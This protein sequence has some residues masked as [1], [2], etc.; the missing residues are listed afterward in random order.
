VLLR[1][2]AP[3]REEVVLDAVDAPLHPLE[4]AVLRGAQGEPVAA[5]RAGGREEGRRSSLGSRDVA[6]EDR[7]QAVEPL[8]DRRR[9]RVV[10]GGA[11][12]E[13]LDVERADVA[14]LE[15]AREQQQAGARDESRRRSIGSPA[16]R[17]ASAR[18]S[19][20]SGS[21]TVASLPSTPAP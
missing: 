19:P 10:A 15:E 4:H 12:V 1:V 20:A 13:Q 7:A 2:L 9:A 6:V 16:P 11:A 5:G 14:L 21:R 3:R 8:R 18:R 17:S